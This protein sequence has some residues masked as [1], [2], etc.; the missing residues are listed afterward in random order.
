MKLSK[1]FSSLILLL[2]AMIWGVAFVA[3]KAAAEVPVFTLCASRS[4]IASVA[5]IP[6]VMV[7]DPVSKNGRRLFSKNSLTDTTTKTRNNDKRGR[8]RYAQLRQDFYRN[9]HRSGNE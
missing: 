2:A 3:Q 6:I 1:L 7:F 5:L 4:I 8:F 9:Y